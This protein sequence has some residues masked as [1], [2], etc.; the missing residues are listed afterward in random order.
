MPAALDDLM[1]TA[2][3]ALAQMD[4]ARCEALCVEAMGKARAAQDWIMLQRVLLPLQEARRLKRQSAIDG[5]ILLG[6]PN[7]A[8]DI[9][10]LLAGNTQGCVV[11]TWPYNLS[12]ALALDRLVRSKGLPV[13]VLFCDNASDDQSWVVTSYNSPELCVHL[14]APKAAWIG[15]WTDPLSIAPPTPSHWFMQASEAL[16]NA[17]MDAITADPGTLDHF[18]QLAHALIAV[19]DH[20]LL[21]QGLASA[22]KR[23]HEASR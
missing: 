5:P 17:A 14:P 6:T 20:E 22:S 8:G 19:G 13:E 9:E 11:M 3:Q 1:Q 12:D 21:H 16:G 15:T 2:S 4:Y 7:R 18:D 23:L 10:S